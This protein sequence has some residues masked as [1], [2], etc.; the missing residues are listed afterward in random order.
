M[1]TVNVPLLLMVAGTVIEE[2]AEAL[3]TAL[4]AGAAVLL[5]LL[6]QAPRQPGQG[7]T[8]L[9]T[10]APRMVRDAT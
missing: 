4:L 5:L 9:T 3:G 6:P 7:S 2:S 10:A 8:A 1:A